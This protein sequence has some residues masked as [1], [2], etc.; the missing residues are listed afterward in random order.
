LKYPQTTHL[1]QKDFLFC[2]N[3]DM[4]SY[5][6]KMNFLLAPGSRGIS[7]ALRER[8]NVG[9]CAQKMRPS[10]VEQVMHGVT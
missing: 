4:F 8:P 3:P 9:I 7:A 1:A 2:H 6:H 10:Q 5:R